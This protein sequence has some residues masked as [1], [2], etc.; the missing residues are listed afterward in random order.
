MTAAVSRKTSYVV[1]GREPGESKLSK[2]RDLKVSQIYEDG[3]FELV[4]TKPG[5]KSKY[6]IQAKEQLKKVRF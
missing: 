5:K 1:I 2:A 3:L 6:V 4:K